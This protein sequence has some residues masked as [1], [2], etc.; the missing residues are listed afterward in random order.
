MGD[1]IDDSLAIGQKTADDERVILFVKTRDGKALDDALRQRIK[2]G[3]ATA[4]S[5]RHVPAMIVQC[6][7]IPYGTTGKKLEVCS[8]ISRRRR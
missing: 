8:A 5:T 2:K 7:D 3:I 6:P 1:Q 4:L